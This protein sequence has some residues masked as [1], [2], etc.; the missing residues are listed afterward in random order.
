MWRELREVAW[1]LSIVSG[2][3]LASVGIAIIASVAL[4]A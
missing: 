4:A 2:L 3:S 1:L